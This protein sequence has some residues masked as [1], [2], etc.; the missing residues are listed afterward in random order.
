MKTNVEVLE[1]SKKETWLKY[2]LNATGHDLLSNLLY[3]NFTP[4][5]TE[6]DVKERFN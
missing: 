1:K 3:V 6:Y 5:C 2:H 4:L